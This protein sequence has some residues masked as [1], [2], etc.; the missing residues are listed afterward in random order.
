[1]KNQNFNAGQI[2]WASQHDWFAFATSEAVYGW[3]QISGQEPKIKKI[4]SFQLLR[5]WAGY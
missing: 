5:D 4:T 2:K 3:N 1:M